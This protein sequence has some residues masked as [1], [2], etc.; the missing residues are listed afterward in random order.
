MAAVC[1]DIGLAPEVSEQD[2]ADTIYALATDESV[3]LRLTR[4]CGWTPARYA[5]LIARTLNA[6]LT[7]GRPAER[8]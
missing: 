2:A 1:A 3:Y 7:H 8:T 5:D 4:D 6:T